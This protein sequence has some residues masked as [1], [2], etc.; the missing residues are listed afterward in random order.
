MKTYGHPSRFGYKDVCHLW[1]AERWDP[2]ALIKLYK[3]A[4]AAYFVATGHPSRQFRL[5]EFK[6]S[7]ME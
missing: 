6:V 4:G 3:S 7:A 5:L 1:K 2:E